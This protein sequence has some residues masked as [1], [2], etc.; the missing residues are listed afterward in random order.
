MSKEK[1]ERVTVCN[2]EGC[3]W[4]STS[5]TQIVSD[6]MLGDPVIVGGL[7]SVLYDLCLEYDEDDCGA[8]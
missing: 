1:H 5:P 2:G 8:E 7:R 4:L 3:L 6:A